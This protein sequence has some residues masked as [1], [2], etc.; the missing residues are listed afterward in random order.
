[1]TTSSASSSSSLRVC[2]TSCLG[3]WIT[4]LSRGPGPTAVVTSSPNT[5]SQSPSARWFINWFKFGSIS[6]LFWCTPASGLI[7]NRLPTRSICRLISLG[8]WAVCWCVILWANIFGC[9]SIQ[10]C[11]WVVGWRHLHIWTRPPYD[12]CLWVAIIP[13]VI[14]NATMTSTK[15]NGN[16]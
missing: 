9:Y 12:A 14:Y 11:K 2:T 4:T 8:Q 6:Y 10:L 1:M 13:V 3:C 15:K 7:L 5:S 16:R